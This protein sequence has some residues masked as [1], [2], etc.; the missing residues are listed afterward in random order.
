MLPYSPP[1]LL[2]KEYPGTLVIDLHTD[3]RPEC[4]VFSGR[5]C[6]FRL[7]E[8]MEQR[9][10]VLLG[11]PG[12]Y[13]DFAYQRFV[14]DRPSVCVPLGQMWSYHYAVIGWESGVYLSHPE[15]H[16]LMLSETRSNQRVDWHLSVL[17]QRA[18]F[19]VSLEDYQPGAVAR[20][21]VILRPQP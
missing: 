19:S 20:G 7:P 6:G 21:E 16:T 8:E 4:G 3:N 9:M 12:T 14:I 5:Q 1:S 10:P 17:G 2:F 15:V 18:R 11:E 13:E